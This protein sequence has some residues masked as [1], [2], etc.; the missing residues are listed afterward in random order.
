MNRPIVWRS[1]MFLCTLSS[2]SSFFFIYFYSAS[3]VYFLCTFY[4]F[5]RFAFFL[6]NFILF[7]L[8]ICL[9]IISSYSISFACLFICVF[10][11]A[12]LLMG[13]KVMLRS[14]CSVLVFISSCFPLFLS[15]FLSFFYSIIYFFTCGANE[16]QEN[17]KKII[18]HHICLSQLSEFHV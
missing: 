3:F 11:G 12:C 6:F 15:V 10:Y 7:H 16:E 17:A 1:L 8:F 5:F 13:K 2:F 14:Y 9:F 18:L 4:L